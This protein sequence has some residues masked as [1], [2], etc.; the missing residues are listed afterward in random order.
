MKKCEPLAEPQAD[1]F[2]TAAIWG[3]QYDYCRL[4]HKILI[5]CVEDHDNQK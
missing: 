1:G 5:H 3:A 2:V 4:Q